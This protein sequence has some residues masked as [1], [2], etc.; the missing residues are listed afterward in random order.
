MSSAAASPENAGYRSYALGLLLT[1]YVFNF[2]DRQILTILTE[3]ISRELKLSNSAIGFLTGPAFALFYTTAGIPIARW[4]DVGVR[5]SIIALAL[6]V[7]SAMTALSGLAQSFMHIAL[8]RLGVGLGEAGCSPPAHS[9]ISDLFPPER[10]ASALSTYALG[11][12]LGGALG[13]ILGGWIGEVYGWRAAFFAVGLPGIALAL[14]V[15]LTLREPA[16]AH[17][18]SRGSMGDALAF[19]SRRRAFVHMASGA[20]LLAFAGYGTGAF[21]PIFLARVHGLSL[22]ETGSWLGGIALVAGGL[23]T[24]LGGVLADRFGARDVRW[25]LRLPAFAALLSLPFTSLYYLWPDG[26]V[27][28]LLSAPASVFGIMYLGPT[29]AMTQSLVPPEMRA[30][31]SAVL[32]FAINAVGLGLGPQF[33]GLFSDALE[34]RFG[35]GAV[36]TASLATA[37][38]A[39]CWAAA[40]Y[41]L[42]ARTLREDLLAKDR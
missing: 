26:R 12:P 40:H 14:A 19:M 35:E 5:R 28:L 7:W 42:G 31:A 39:T 24:F 33:V 37:I 17:V 36:G 32:L 34:P 29:F 18:A 16:R 30:F 41:W 1:V 21:S 2:L 20:A 25:Y 22:G 23:G 8:A 13:T 15:R 3:P 6:L 9:L 4:A 38:V 27:A 11:V 10:R